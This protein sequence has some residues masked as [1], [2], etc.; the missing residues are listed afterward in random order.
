MILGFPQLTIA[1][2]KTVAAI[3]RNW[4]LPLVKINRMTAGVLYCTGFINATGN[5]ATPWLRS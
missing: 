4:E 1:H 5:L 3:I 2:S